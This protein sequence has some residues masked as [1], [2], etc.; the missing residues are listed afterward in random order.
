MEGNTHEVEYKHI[1]RRVLTEETTHGRDYIVATRY[2]N[3]THK[4]K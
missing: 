3:D 2:E 1:K 4:K